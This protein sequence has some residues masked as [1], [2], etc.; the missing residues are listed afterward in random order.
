M[1]APPNYG[2]D[3]QRRFRALYPELAAGHELPLVPFLLEGVAGVAAL[4]QADG[5]HPTPEGHRRMADTVWAVLGPLLRAQ[6]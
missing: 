3:Y 4:N 1:Q 2:S 6:R 5:V